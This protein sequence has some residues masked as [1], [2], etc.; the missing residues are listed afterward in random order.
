ML[1]CGSKS[2]M[3]TAMPTLRYYLVKI[4]PLLCLW[5]RNC[6]K[7]NRRKTSTYANRDKD[8]TR[9]QNHDVQWENNRFSHIDLYDQNDYDSL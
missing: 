1:R 5:R 3:E 8:E 9:T 6:V 7:H 2:V 4:H